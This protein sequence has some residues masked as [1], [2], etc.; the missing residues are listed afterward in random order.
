[1]STEEK[2][3]TALDLLNRA[4]EIRAFCEAEGITPGRDPEE[5]ARLEMTGNVV[6]LWTG[7]IVGRDTERIELT[8]LGEIASIV[9]KRFRRW[10]S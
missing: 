1:M 6:D 9:E 2:K 5:I 10:R 8:I 7:E 3:P 4:S